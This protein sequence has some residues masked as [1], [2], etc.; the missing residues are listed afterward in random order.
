MSRIGGFL[1]GLE[2]DAAQRVEEALTVAAQVPVAL[3]D[4]LEGRRDLILRHGGTDD[5]PER[6][7][8]GRRAAE[9]DLVPLL[10][11]LV[12]PEHADVADVMVTAGVHAAGH[13]QLDLAEVVEVI[14]VVEALLHLAGDRDG[15]GVG[16]RAEVEAR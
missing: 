14:E 1:E 15:A 9:A 3:D 11:V 7:D 16:E 8:A 13:L 4:T 10:A 6:G 5:L 12:D 2:S